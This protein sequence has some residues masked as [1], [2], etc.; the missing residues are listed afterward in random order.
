MKNIFAFLIGITMFFSYSSK[1]FAGV[2]T[3]CVNCS[4]VIQQILDSV[5]Q[6]NELSTAIEQY[7]QLVTQTQNQIFM[8]EAEIKRL[9]AL[10]GSVVSKY[11]DQFSDLGKLINDLNVYK[12]DLTALMDIYRQVYPDFND[13]VTFVDTADPNAIQNEWRK[14][15]EELDKNT[16]QAFQL[17]N[18]ALNHMVKDKD[19]YEAHIKTL[20]SQENETQVLQ[21]SNKLT[22]LMLSEIRSLQ[23]LTAMQLQH[24]SSK[25]AKNLK[26]DQT[27]Q[28]LWEKATQARKFESY[29][30]ANPY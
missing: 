7:K 2:P 8:M 1:A 18:M 6:A 26:D 19:A 13:M 17:S 16:R 23:S 4:N 15:S 28:L 5:T 11:T 20:L 3:T 12:G 25:E 10:P 22:S 30:G 29:S 14:R 27:T 21:A 24:N 9:M